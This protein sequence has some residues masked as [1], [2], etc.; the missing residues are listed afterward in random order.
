MVISYTVKASLEFLQCVIVIWMRPI[1]SAIKLWFYQSIHMLLLLATSNPLKDQF[2]KT[3]SLSLSLFL[4]LVFVSL[5]LL[6]ISLSLSLSLVFLSFYLSLSLSLKHTDAY[7]SNREFLCWRTCSRCLYH[8]KVHTHSFSLST[9]FS[10]RNTQPL[11][12]WL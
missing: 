4:S 7:N 9:I 12:R 5:S 11:S 3:F 6:T 2:C 8:P 1:N 10:I